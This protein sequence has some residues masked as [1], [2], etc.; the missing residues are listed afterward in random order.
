[1]R[2][3]SPLQDETSMPSDTSSSRSIEPARRA[4]FADR[5]KRLQRRQERDAFDHFFP[6]I[7]WLLAAASILGLLLAG[8]HYFVAGNFDRTIW[9]LV[10]TPFVVA[11]L[12][13]LFKQVRGH[14]HPGLDE[15]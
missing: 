8:G 4:R 6:P 3:E 1:M 13:V 2:Q 10:P 14:N 15:P 12:M 11:I 5:S 7:I 9:G